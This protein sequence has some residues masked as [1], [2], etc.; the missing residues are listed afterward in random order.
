[1]LDLIDEVGPGGSFIATPETAKRCR[2]EIYTSDLIDRNA[3]TTW[4]ENGAETMLDRIQSKLTDILSRPPSI[5]L[6]SEVLDRI[7][8]VIQAAE[9]REGTFVF[10]RTG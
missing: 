2:E 6:S 9:K 1:M 3:W 8:A 5:Q 10:E 4:Q 7:S